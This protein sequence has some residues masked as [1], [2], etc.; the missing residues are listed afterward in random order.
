MVPFVARTFLSSSRVTGVTGA[1]ER[2]AAAK[3]GFY[4]VFG[5]NQPQNHR[6]NISTTENHGEGTENHREKNLPQRTTEIK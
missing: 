4:S 1:I 3:V 6:V 5:K 2:S